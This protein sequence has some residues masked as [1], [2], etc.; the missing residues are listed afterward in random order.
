MS[1][2]HVAELR[3]QTHLKPLKQNPSPGAQKPI[4]RHPKPQSIKTP[5]QNLR[6]LNALAQH[7]HDLLDVATEDAVGAW[8]GV[9]G[10]KGVGESLAETTQQLAPP[11]PLRGANSHATSDA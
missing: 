11:G 4:P 10:F 1:Q 7:H 9:L 3:N 8:Y 6:E 5:K 2:T